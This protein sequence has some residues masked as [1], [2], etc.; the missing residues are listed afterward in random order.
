MLGKSKRGGW[1]GGVFLCQRLG[2]FNS[3]RRVT[4]GDVVNA[5]DV[6]A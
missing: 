1:G 2:E 4:Q 3:R 5:P 6:T